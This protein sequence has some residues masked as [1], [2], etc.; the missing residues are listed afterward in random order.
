MKTIKA[1]DLPKAD[2][3]KLGQAFY[4]LAHDDFEA[5]H[6][7]DQELKDTDA[8]L[9]CQKYIKIKNEGLIDQAGRLIAGKQWYVALGR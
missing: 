8:G 7:L 4:N 3:R 6:L 2:L 9:I 5:F 1:K